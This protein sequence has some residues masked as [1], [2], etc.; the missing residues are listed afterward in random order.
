MGETKMFPMDAGMAKDCL[1][2]LWTWLQMLT[3]NEAYRPCAVRIWR[4]F[5][6]ILEMWPELKDQIDLCDE[7]IAWVERAD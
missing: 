7:V 6:V 2:G 3:V 5:Q 4:H 1:I